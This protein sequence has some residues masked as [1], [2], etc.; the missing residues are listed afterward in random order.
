MRKKKRESAEAEE[1]ETKKKGIRHF[2]RFPRRKKEE[3]VEVK[4]PELK[5]VE[6]NFPKISEAEQKKYIGRH[7]AIVDG[8]IVTSAGGARRTLEMAK[9]EYSGKEIELRYVAN[10]KLLLKCKCLEKS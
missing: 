7:I 10:E 6:K 8:K 2:L 5:E 9:R 1:P 3:V 4:K